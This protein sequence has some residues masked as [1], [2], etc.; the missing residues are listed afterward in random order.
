VLGHAIRADGANV[1]REQ[2][3]LGQAVLYVIWPNVAHFLE[4]RLAQIEAQANGRG[5]W[6]AATPLRELPFEYRLKQEGDAPFRPVGDFST[7]FYVE[8]QDYG[9]V[10]VNNRVFFNSRADAGLAGYV[11]CPPDASGSYTANCFG[12]DR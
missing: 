12:P 5:I 3:R 9:R 7:R 1:N 2:L 8:A 4:Y 11:P 6:S 10:S